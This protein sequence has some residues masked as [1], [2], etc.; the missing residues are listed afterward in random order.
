MGMNQIKV[1]IVPF[2]TSSYCTKARTPWT[3]GIRLHRNYLAA[4]HH[5]NNLYA[6]HAGITRQVVNLF[7][8][9]ISL[10]LDNKNYLPYPKPCK[11]MEFI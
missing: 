6:P 8:I 11:S 5:S 3:P 9:Y 4:L 1:T 10:M 2:T 7:Y